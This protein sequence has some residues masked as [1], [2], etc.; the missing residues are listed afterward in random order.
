[1][2]QRRG[3][4]GRIGTTGVRVEKRVVVHRDLTSDCWR[5]SDVLD[6]SWMMFNIIC[7]LAPTHHVQRYWVT[8]TLPIKV[9]V[10]AGVVL[11][12]GAV[13]LGAPIA[14]NRN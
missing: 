14:A 9:K 11:C 6:V 13:T 7:E 1:M 10:I 12:V 8:K 3:K 2:V 4:A 5:A